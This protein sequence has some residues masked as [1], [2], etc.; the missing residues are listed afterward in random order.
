MRKLLLIVAFSFCLMPSAHA[1]TG[2]SLL[3]VGSNTWGVSTQ[4]FTEKGFSIDDKEPLVRLEKN[5]KTQPSGLLNSSKLTAMSRRRNAP[6]QQGFQTATFFEDRL[7]RFKQTVVFKADRYTTIF[8]TIQDFE[9]QIIGKP[10]VMAEAAKLRKDSYY[11]Y[12]SGDHIY[13]MKLLFDDESVGGVLQI[14]SRWA[15]METTLIQYE[16]HLKSVPKP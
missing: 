9:R 1:K 11:E 12:R 3:H 6:G 7:V 5:V 13:T 4:Y 2:A 16:R 10:F 15:A 8:E 14:E